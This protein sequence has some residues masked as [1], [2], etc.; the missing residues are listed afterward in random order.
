MYGLKDIFEKREDNPCVAP[1]C[2]I[3]DI[4]AFSLDIIEIITTF[5]A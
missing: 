1:S 3:L 5:I 2:D 4:C